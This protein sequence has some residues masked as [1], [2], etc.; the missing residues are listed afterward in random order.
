MNTLIKYLLAILSGLVGIALVFWFLYEL[1][2]NL[3]V[4]LMTLGF[5]VVL[6]LLIILVERIRQKS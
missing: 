1:F 2:R 5:I 6:A 3:P 4:I